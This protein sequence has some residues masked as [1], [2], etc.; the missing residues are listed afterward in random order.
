MFKL[1]YIDA[2]SQLAYWTDGTTTI[3]IPISS[4]S[5]HGII[6]ELHRRGWEVTA[7]DRR[8]VISD[9]GITYEFE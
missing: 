4:S 5:I 2:G 7:A 1:S 9:I 6:R 3:A 8:G